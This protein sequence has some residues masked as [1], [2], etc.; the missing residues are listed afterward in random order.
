MRLPDVRERKRVAAATLLWLG[1]GSA[2]LFAQQSTIQ[3]VVKDSSGAAIPG[4]SVTVS[5]T[6]TAVAQTTTSN[7]EGFYS[8]PFLIPGVY[9]IRASAQGFAARTISKLTLDVGATARADFS[10]EIG[11]V[12]TSVEVSSTA[13]LLNTETTTVGQVIDNKRVVELPL[14]GRNYLELAQLTTGVGP[15][16]P[17]MRSGPRGAFT[18]LGSRAYQTN[19]VLD[20]V[21]NSLRYA[22][23]QIASEAQSVTPSVDAVQEFK[24]VTNN[25]SA[26]YGYRMGGTVIVQTK[27]G[28][29]QYHGG[30]YEF[31]RNDR[32]AANNFFANASGQ[33][34]TVY[35]RNQFGVTLGGRIVADK[36]FFFGSYEGTRVR[37]GENSRP[38]VPLVARKNGDF[39]DRRDRLIFDPGTTRQVGTRWLRDPFPGNVIPSSRFDP[40][41]AKIVAMYPDPTLPG[42]TNNFFFS[43]SNQDDTNQY[44]GRLDHNFNPSHRVFFRY[45]RRA[46][47][48]VDPGPLPLPADGGTWSNIDVTARSYVGN[49][50]AVLSPVMNNE[51]RMGYTTTDTV[52]DIPWE[53][54]YNAQLGVQG[55]PDFGKANDR[56]MLRITPAEYTELGPRSF[57]P[58]ESDARV[59]QVSN[60]L[61]RVQGRHVRKLGFE[62]RQQIAYRH[63]ARYAR[64][65]MQFNRS[66]TQD[67]NNRAAT[68]DGVADLLL[69]MAFG[70]NF[71]N[72]T[73]EDAKTRSYSLF[74]QDDWKVSDRLTLNLGLRW[75]RFGLPS[76]SNYR[77][78]GRFTLGP[79]GTS[80]YEV[81]RPK[82][83]GDNGGELDNNNFAPRVGLA[84]RIRGATVLRSGFGVF[85]ATPDGFNQ[86]AFWFNG[87]PD[88]SEFTFPSDR[89]VQPG[90]VLSKGFPAG[91]VPATQV[92]ENVNINTILQ[93]GFPAQY[94]MHWFV[95]L[96]HQLPLETVLTLSCMGNASR[97]MV[98]QRDVNAVGEPGP[99]TLESREAWP[100]FGAIR[101][102]QPGGN[103]SYNGFA[104]KAEKRF[105]QGLTFLASYTLAHAIDDG[106]G[107]GSD[108]EGT[109]R[110]PF[111][112]AMDRG[113]S[114]Y[115]RR[116][117]LVTS[118]VYDLPFGRGRRWGSAWGALARNILGGWQAGGILVL[119]S[120]RPYS[121]TVSGNPANNSGSNYANRI[122][123]GSLPSS[124]RSLDRWFDL[125]AFTIP[126]Q[127]TFGNAGRNILVAPRTNTMD[128]KIGKN[129]QVVEK[130][131]LE[132][133][134]EMFNFT[135]TPNFGA[136]NGTLNAPS[137]GRITGAG[138]PRIV[139]FG[140]KLSF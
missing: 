135:N 103:L 25:N 58:N 31:L 27:S 134:C 91:L 106:P 137:A 70:G 96:Q 2:A 15:A 113:N 139:Q 45:S 12:E 136:P 53:T 110:N 101:I 18:A 117:A 61:T 132:F 36:T 127:Y 122:G 74:F 47:D 130:Y 43:P 8:V 121:I 89:L 24:V 112:I 60:H 40:L 86:D 72:P 100:Y 111:N 115:D 9:S 52:L 4:A 22:G 16:G 67:P 42:T 109:F 11:Q 76:F 97:Q 98:W 114:D 63:A 81:L 77:T 120:G 99:G 19:I 78:M 126:Q 66:F 64:G 116:H 56:G 26:E 107:V 123:H 33:D 38:T 41:G 3:G 93:A 138:S 49:W 102:W 48:S 140:L 90:L 44:D 85:Y 80:R 131:R 119:R 54:N 51:F 17:L 95:D 88:W 59:L 118:F 84:Y 92:R 65:H 32:F 94:A 69:G 105:S 57:S 133:R 128:F 29:N 55:I 35:K 10:L 108:A 124:Q 23:G 125:S 14:N 1:V 68:G 62:F 104:A 7:E 39:S 129:F 83:P 73:G 5:N 37:I 13:A 20:G 34:K 28:S 71:G 50:N 75:D 82:G 30:V 46:L 87:P 6:G 79:P 21:D